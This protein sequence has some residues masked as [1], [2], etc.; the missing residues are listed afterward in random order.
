[1]QV[2]GII[3][4]YNPFH[5]GHQY[6]IA[7]TKRKLP[8]AAVICFMSGNFVQRG[9]P[10]LLHKTAR[11][12]A[13]VLSGADVVFELPV[14]A[15]LS[16]AERFAKAGVWLAK[17]C[18][19]VTHLS[20]G[21]ECGDIALLQKAAFASNQPEVH[22]TRS[23]L[24]KQGLPYPKAAAD[25][26][27]AD[28]QPIIQSPNNLLGIE[29]IKAIASLQA[30]F[31]PITVTRKG[32]AHD[33]PEETKAFPSASAIRRIYREGRTP[34]EGTLPPAMLAAVEE[35]RAQGR[36]PVNPALLDTAVLAALRRADIKQLANL[37][38]VSEG[39]ENRLFKAARHCYTIEDLLA[40]VKTKRYSLAR[41]RRCLYACLL[42]LSKASQ[43]AMPAYLRVLAVSET[44]RQVLA[45]MRKISTLPVVTKPAMLKR[46]NGQAYEQAQLEAMADHLFA[47]AFPNPGA[48]S[49]VSFFTASPYIV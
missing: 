49:S 37:P 1:M 46:L 15:V 32:S 18:G 39:L 8:G 26:L 16:P 35:E 25:A 2:A 27:P 9:E 28:L 3:A 4:E 40:S 23:A 44:G 14:S 38:E 33:E 48:G 20:F 45:N 42:G 29:Y 7:E 31:I 21:S 5:V 11:A 19:V 43:R 17:A 6:H 13:A 34:P 36:F 47:L 41:L 30:H 22:A 24:L 10:A 12:K